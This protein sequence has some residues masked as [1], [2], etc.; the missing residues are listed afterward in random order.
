MDTVD[1]FR[2][3]RA[4]SWVSGGIIKNL[5]PLPPLP[6]LSLSQVAKKELALECD[7]TFELACQ[8]RYRAL[9]AADLQLSQHFHVPDVVPGLSSMRILTS[10]WVQGVPID[11][12][13]A[14][15]EGSSGEEPA[16]GCCT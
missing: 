6:P 10:E 13:G 14:Q 8:Q 15:Y 1:I 4:L 16:R 5:M 11:K 12:V 7:Y 3:H 9:I 2:Q